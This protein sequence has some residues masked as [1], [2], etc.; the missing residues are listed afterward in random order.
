M[1]HSRAN[2]GDK[3]GA[4]VSQKR[5]VENVNNQLP[6]SISCEKYKGGFL[7]RVRRKRLSVEIQESKR[8]GYNLNYQN[9]IC[10]GF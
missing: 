10:S 8:Y 9:N 1:V 5:N 3:L 7:A 6:P 2:K 4:K